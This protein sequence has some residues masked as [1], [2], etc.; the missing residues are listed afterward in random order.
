ME[1]RKKNVQKYFCIEKKIF[2]FP[3]FVITVVEKGLLAILLGERLR[4]QHH[5]LQKITKLKF[6]RK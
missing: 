1:I 3:S 4:N 6:N 5:K 2:H